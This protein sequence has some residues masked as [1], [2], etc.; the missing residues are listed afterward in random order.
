MATSETEAANGS[1]SIGDRFPA[2]RGLEE[3]VERAKLA[4]ALAEAQAARITAMLPEG[5][6]TFGTD[7]VTSSDNMT[8]LATVLAQNCA[9]RLSWDVAA[10]V[11]DAARA[12]TAAADGRR[13]YRFVITEDPSLIPAIDTLA[14][15]RRQARALRTRIAQYASAVQ[16]D[17]PEPGGNDGGGGGKEGQPPPDDRRRG[18]AP[19]IAAAVIT[20]LVQAAGW[21]TNALRKSYEVSGA[22]VAVA[23]LALA[24]VL[25]EDLRRR[26]ER[27]EE[28]TVR[29]ARFS[30]TGDAA[31]IATVLELAE[32]GE[33]TLGRLGVHEGSK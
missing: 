19:P 7:S 12:R 13:H 25:A 32:S 28:V 5:Q 24:P 6:P 2:L 30:P 22:A 10:I 21:A 4:Q 1:P 31:I 9:L 15:L 17:R 26:S 33:R 23:D 11:L 18:I 3:D 14:L 29:L 16:P 8:G 27:D 20:G